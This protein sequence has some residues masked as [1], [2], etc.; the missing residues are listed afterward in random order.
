MGILD[1]YSALNRMMNRNGLKA[2]KKKQ[3]GSEP[4]RTLLNALDGMRGYIN[5]GDWKQLHDT[6]IAENKRFDDTSL[7]HCLMRICTDR[8]QVA[9]VQHYFE[10]IL[11]ELEEK[12]MQKILLSNEENLDI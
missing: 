12:E 4:S 5:R 10:V 1:N 9:Q 3:G 8:N 2:T 7:K 11:P 6:V